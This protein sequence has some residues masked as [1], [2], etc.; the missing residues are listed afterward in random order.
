MVTVLLNLISVEEE[1]KVEE[2]I[3]E[4]SSYQGSAPDKVLKDSESEEE[5]NGL[6]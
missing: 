2:E 1:Q 5:V 3:L 6:V 4:N